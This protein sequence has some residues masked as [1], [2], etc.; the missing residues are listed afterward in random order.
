VVLIQSR[1]STIPTLPVR[2]RKLLVVPLQ[3]PEIDMVTPQVVL[4]GGRISV[5]GS[6]LKGQV[7][8]VSFGPIV[9]DPV[10]ARSFQVDVNVPPGLL[11]GINTAQVIQPLD[12]GTPNEPHNGFK[13]NLAA[14][15]LAPQITN[16]QPL[17]AARGATLNLSVSPPVGRAQNV[18]LL[19]G[20]QTISIPARPA[21]AQPCANLSFPIPADFAPGTFL[22]RVQ[23]DGA[24]SPL[25]ADTNQASPT[26]NQ[27]IGPTLTIT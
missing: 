26:F 18:V 10:K 9:T 8:K 6:N 23:V 7:T 19:A 1:D 16:G 11:P 22:V 14:F 21:N 5:Q 25:I 15:M 3:Q 13:S 2:D 20:N 12:F 24:Q 27:Y 17:V 4:A